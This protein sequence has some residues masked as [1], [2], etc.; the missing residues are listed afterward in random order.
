ML[1]LRSLGFT[2][3]PIHHQRVQGLVTEFT[4][5]H[6][7]C[8]CPEINAVTKDVVKTILLIILLNWLFFGDLGAFSC[9]LH[10]GIGKKATWHKG[11]EG[12]APKTNYKN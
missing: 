8:A 4:A 2:A 12:K 3:L 10:P 7:I 11:D 9:T 5:G 6:L 1:A